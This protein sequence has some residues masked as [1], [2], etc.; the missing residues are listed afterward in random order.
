MDSFTVG[1]GFD[2]LIRI[3]GGLSLGV[4]DSW[5]SVFILS[6]VLV[7]L[8]MLFGVALISPF[9]INYLAKQWTRR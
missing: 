5:E 3:T 8:F 4:I 6:V 7:V 9:I 2:S 1:D